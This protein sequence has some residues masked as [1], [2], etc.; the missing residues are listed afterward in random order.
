MI[1]GFCNVHGNASLKRSTLL[2]KSAGGLCVDQV[3]ANYGQ[4]VAF[5]A[6]RMAATRT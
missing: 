3:W 1:C 4:R 2:G 5:C 6:A